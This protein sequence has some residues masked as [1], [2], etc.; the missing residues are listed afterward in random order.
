MNWVFL[1]FKVSLRMF[2]TPS[3]TRK[4]KV[5]VILYCPGDEVHAVL[6]K[7]LVLLI[8]F[9]DYTDYKLY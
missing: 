3:H 7:T 6:C 1:S 9:C 4:K 2:A 8:K 5:L